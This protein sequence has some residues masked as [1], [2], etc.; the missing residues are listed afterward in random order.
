MF[1][2]LVPALALTTHLIPPLSHLL[3]TSLSAVTL[4]A[5]LRSATVV[6]ESSSAPKESPFVTEALLE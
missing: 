2:E 5:V 6:T 4:T 3:L 1:A